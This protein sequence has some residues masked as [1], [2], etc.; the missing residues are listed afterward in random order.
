MRYPQYS[1]VV[2]AP[3]PI[4]IPLAF[5]LPPGEPALAKF[6]DTWIALKR[7]DGTL[8]DLYQYWILGRDR[9]QAPPRW[10]IIRDVLHW[11]K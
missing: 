1:V 6:V 3:R 11:V 2:P 8:D 4:Q 9:S 5:A 10:S 7:E